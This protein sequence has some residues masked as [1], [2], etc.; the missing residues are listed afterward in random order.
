MKIT[1]V[2]II[3]LLGLINA[4]AQTADDVIKKWTN[5]MGGPEKL[6]SIKSVY[7]EN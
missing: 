1:L 7:T 2:C 5:A 4:K 3:S 6:A